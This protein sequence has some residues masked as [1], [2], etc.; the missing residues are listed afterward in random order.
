MKKV[1]GKNGS[2]S[3]AKPDT[4]NF[5]PSIYFAKNWYESFTKNLVFKFE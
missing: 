4:A 5:K 3:E 2:T 1:R